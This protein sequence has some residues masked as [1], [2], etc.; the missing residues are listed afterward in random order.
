[1]NEQ[2]FDWDKIDSSR[3]VNQSPTGAGTVSG[4]RISDSDFSRFIQILADKVGF[5]LT[6][7]NTKF[8]HAWRRAENTNAL[9]NPFATTLNYKNDP[10]MT[11]FNL[12][13]RGQGVKNFSTVEYGADATAI[14][15]KL[16]YYTS[17]IDKL[18]NNETTAAELAMDPSL[19]TWGTTS[20]NPNLIKSLL[21]KIDISPD[22]TVSSIDNLQDIT[23]DLIKFQGIIKEA[24]DDMYQFF[25]RNASR[26]FSKYKGVF[27]DDEIG[28]YKYGV[29]AYNDGWWF[30][31]NNPDKSLEKIVN[32]LK[33][34]Q[35]TGIYTEKQ[36]IKSITD[37]QIKEILNLTKITQ[38][39][40]NNGIRDGKSIPS[41]VI[42]N[43][44]PSIAIYRDGEF[45]PKEYKFYWNYM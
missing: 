26:Y 38:F 20:S 34:I 39:I 40:L 22:D 44:L 12:A 41:V 19:R 28:A 30:N 45:W 13:N 8:L 42:G 2:Y 27:N 21:D 11:R 14:T 9:N 4:T 31:K 25:G 16:R 33:E 10:G 7:E 23:A 1:M 18:K 35:K 3:T 36:N 37:R 24:Y 43:K 5:Q 29:R 32:Q 17:L 6:S 15:M